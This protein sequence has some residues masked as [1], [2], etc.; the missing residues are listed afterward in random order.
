[1]AQAMPL[2]LPFAVVSVIVV[3]PSEPSA[4]FHANHIWSPGVVGAASTSSFQSAFGPEMAP[5]TAQ[6]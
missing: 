1:M 4:F 2:P 5:P 6:L 3:P